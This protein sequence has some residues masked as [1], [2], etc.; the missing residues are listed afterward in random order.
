MALD[1]ITA[2]NTYDEA[3]N[4][5]VLGPIENCSTSAAPGNNAQHNHIVHIVL[6]DV[7]DII[8]WQARLNYDGGRMRPSAFNAA[9]F[10]DS[11]RGQNLSFTNLPID[12]ASGVHRDLIPAQSIPAAAPGPQS[13]LI[14]AVYNGH[15]TAEISPDTP[16]KAPPDDTSYS[17][18]GGGVVAALTLQVL[19]GQ[20]GQASLTMDIDDGSPNPPGTD[21]QVF[22][23]AGAQTVHL[24]ENAMFD[25]Y[26]AEGAGCVPPA[27]ITPVPGE[28]PGFP[29]TSPVNGAGGTSAPGATSP[30][31]VSPGGAG[32]G[33]ASPDGASTN[34]APDGQTAGTER[35]DDG[36]G[37]SLWVYLL[38]IVAP[39]AA[40]SAFAAWRFRSRL[41]WLRR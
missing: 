32:T 28:D 8:A 26:H 4:T 12:L 24:A 2:G 15:Q 21:L 23:S 20:A 6:Q 31:E 7:V 18:P 16:A 10:A 13:A 27:G 11:I 14:G 35:S 22:S 39:L 25:G 19:P 30:G 40:L 38:A 17:A 37:T 41:P 5:M 34:G 3:S 29:D 9:P 1:M 33:S 36:G